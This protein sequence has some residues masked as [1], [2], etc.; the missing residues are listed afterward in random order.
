VRAGTFIAAGVLLVALVA[1]GC[2]GDDEERESGT[3][4]SRPTTG[5]APGDSPGAEVPEAADID[6]GG[7]AGQASPEAP[8]TGPETGEL[9]DPDEEGVA[10]VVRAYVTALNG[11]DAAA[12]CAVF[13]PGAIRIAE[14]PARR[15]G[16][17]RSL[18]ASIGTRPSG[19]G[20]AW[21]RTRIVE[22]GAVSVE[23]GG[24]RATATVI[25]RFRDRKQPSIE[26]DVVYLERRGGR[27]LLAKPS[28]TFYRAVGYADPPLRALTPP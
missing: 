15:G 26:E 19:G 6:Q 24:A 5:A 14:L 9:S 16:C 27:W 3:V 25:H 28:A 12:A 22:I 11:R 8:A 20:P 7:A 21:Q 4:G 23:G 2:G 13:A 18:R 10:R 1:G 17:V